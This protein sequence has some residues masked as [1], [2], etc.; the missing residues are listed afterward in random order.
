VNFV[1]E[2]VLD[3]WVSGEFEK[4][5]LKSLKDTKELASFIIL[6]AIIADTVSYPAD[7]IVRNCE[8][9]SSS[10]KDIEEDSTFLTAS[11]QIR[12]GSIIE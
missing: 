1:S 4:Y 7:M 8:M 5:P 11:C 9:I 10:S 3:F 6:T 12:R 2:I